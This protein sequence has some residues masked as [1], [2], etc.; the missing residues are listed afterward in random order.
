MTQINITKFVAQACPR[1]YSASVAELGN[2]AG[3]ITWAQAQEDAGY[4][5]FLNTEADLQTFR[6]WLKP[7]GA[8]DEEEIAAMSPRDLNA[9]LIQW[10]A[11]DMRECGIS[12]DMSSADWQAV[13]Q[14]QQGNAPGNIWHD[15]ET[16]ETFF[17]LEM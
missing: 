17:S 12:A 1:D 14:R 15:N 10:I 9:L 11:G 2:N 16:N 5:Q 7:W 13:E 6:D 8:W 3:R 4:W